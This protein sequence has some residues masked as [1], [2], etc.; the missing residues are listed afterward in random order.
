MKASISRRSAL[1]VLGTLL[2]VLFPALLLSC[3]KDGG[4]DSTVLAFALDS[5]KLGKTD[6]LR[7]EI[8]NGNAP[9]PGDT[10]KPVQVITVKTPA[11]LKVEIKLSELVRSDFSVVVIGIGPGGETQRKLFEFDD[12]KPDPNAKPSVLLAVLTAVNLDM[13]PGETKATALTLAPDDAADK[14][15]AYSSADTTIVKVVGTNKDSLRAIA[16]GTAKITV[17]ALVGGAKGVFTIT[18]S[19]KVRL[20]AIDAKPL[21]GVVGDTL[22]PDLVFTPSDATDKT[23]RLRSLDTGFVTVATLKLVAKSAGSGKVEV[24]TTDGGLKD[25]FDVAVGNSAIRLK[26]ISSRPLSGLIGDS[27]TPVLTFDPADASDKG[28]QVKSLDTAI[29]R[30]GGTK[31]VGRAEGKAKV[32]ITANDGGIKD[33]FEV[34]ISRQ[35][36][37]VN[38]L[39]V[40][41]L[42]GLI[43]DRVA[44]VPAFNPTDA[45][46]RGFTLESG[47]TSIAS[48]AGDSL[49][50]RKLGRVE[51]VA[52]SS[53]GG[54]RAT[55]NFSVERPRFDPDVKAITTSKCAP[56][57]I[58]PAALD[59]GDSALFVKSGMDALRRI[60]RP[61]GDKDKMPIAGSPNGGLTTRQLNILVEWL[62]RVVIPVKDVTVSDLTVNLGDTAK[63]ALVFD[64]P[65]ASNQDFVLVSQDTVLAPVR[66]KV[67]VPGKIGQTTVQVNGLE[68]GRSLSFKL[69]VLAP[70][71]AKNMK[72]IIQLKCFPCHTTGA[73]NW[74]DSAN[75]LN[76]GQAALIRLQLPVG[77]SLRMPLVGAPNGDLT[78]HELRVILGW[79]QSKV[80]PLKG[81]TVGPD[82]LGVGS[83]KTPVVT[84]DPP[85]ANNK[86][87]AL[88]S[89]DTSILAI[90]G[91]EM[92]GRKIG[93]VSVQI[94]TLEND[95]TKTFSVKVLPVP[96]DSVQ[97]VDTAGAV[98]DTVEPRILFFPED[99]SNQ[100]YTISLPNSSTVVKLDGALKVVGLAVGL[101]TLRVTSTDGGKVATF[102]FTVGP[103]LP[104]SLSVPDTNG[105][106]SGTDLVT[107]RLIW[108]PAATTN[109]AYTLSIPPAD[110]NIA[111]ARGTQILGKAI[112]VVNVVTAT[113]VADPTVKATFKFTVGP[114]P[115]VGLSVA[116]SVAV[117]GST[118]SPVITWNPTNATTKTFTLS[119]LAPNAANLSVSGNNILAQHLTTTGVVRVT[120]TANT[121]AFAN[122][123]VRVIRPVF[124]TSSARAV[125][126]NRCGQCHVAG[127]AFG[128]QNWL[129]STTVVGFRPGSTTVRHD[130]L[131]IARANPALAPVNR[132]PPTY[133][134]DPSPLTDDDYKKVVNW[135]NA[136]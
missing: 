33:T 121:S 14:R 135:L 42:R 11:S 112:G 107:P 23:F 119:V 52:I 92:V 1:R 12:F 136:K 6:S 41:D 24:T 91:D 37:R 2:L 64:P 103:V 134:I 18:V 125:F 22:V 26:D 114:V 76:S 71:F 122:W 68:G 66:G 5:A 85:N 106:S 70:D 95:Q 51:V 43:E 111:A 118:V 58:P 34:T 89:P 57:H 81:F 123:S 115:V 61:D 88:F 109:K 98:G 124:T 7:F 19:S 30:I 72:P 27:L 69:T 116:S 8:Y 31:V 39:S 93:N 21:S 99:A 3:F 53:D 78:P 45:T 35:A 49:V 104:K 20:V 87:F 28:F 80:I 97:V 126:L 47:D 128:V 82:S 67:L 46:S 65:T 83:R 84:F 108:T 56:C 55:F 10:T 48:V 132:M 38:G 9:A 105:T 120:S 13:R 86:A 102:K 127:N 101:D 40:T 32:E 79:L 44:V 131:I 133:A 63:P 117:V 50:A 113:S 17:T 90:E 15:V 59:W 62:G 73:L 54:H 36:I 129:D 25:T 77:D 16:D 75:F 100:G 74:V 4:K 96:V 29:A 110:T 94:R 130:S 60:T